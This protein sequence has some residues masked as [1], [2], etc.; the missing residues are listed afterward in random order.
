[1][2]VVILLIFERKHERF[3]VEAEVKSFFEFNFLPKS[4]NVKKVRNFFSLDPKA[5]KDLIF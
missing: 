1:M 2:V 3:A 4:R 5:T